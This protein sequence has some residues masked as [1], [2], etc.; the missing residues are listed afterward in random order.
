MNYD[1]TVTGFLNIRRREKEEEDSIP[2]DS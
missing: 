1:L 2:A